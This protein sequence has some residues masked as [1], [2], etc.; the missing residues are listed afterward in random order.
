M[1]GGVSGEYR[2]SGSEIYRFA[3]PGGRREKLREQHETRPGFREFADVQRGVE[4][5]R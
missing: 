4:E 1:D 2:P 5:F 3:L